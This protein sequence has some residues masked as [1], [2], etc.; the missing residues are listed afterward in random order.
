M[1]DKKQMIADIDLIVG[2]NSEITDDTHLDLVNEISDYVEKL[3]KELLCILLKK[4]NI[5]C[6]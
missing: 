3:Q 2:R 6:Q 4:E 5:N 1:I